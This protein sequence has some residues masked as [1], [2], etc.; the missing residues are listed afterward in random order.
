MKTKI[1]FGKITNFY[2]SY[3]AIAKLKKMTDN[4]SAFIERLINK[5]FENAKRE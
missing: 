2:L 4:K 3:E 5:E 1:K